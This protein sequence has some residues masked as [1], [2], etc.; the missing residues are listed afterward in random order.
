MLHYFTL[1]TTVSHNLII[2]GNETNICIITVRIFFMY[3]PHNTNRN[4]SPIAL[5]QIPMLGTGIHLICGKSARLVP[6]RNVWRGTI[7]NVHHNCIINGFT[8]QLPLIRSCLVIF[9]IWLYVNTNEICCT[10]PVPSGMN[11]NSDG[12]PICDFN[13]PKTETSKHITITLLECKWGA[14]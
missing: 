5:T 14:M 9:A 7:G 11:V 4:G 12:V 10:T 8:I 13:N 6:S 3:V 1:S 2:P